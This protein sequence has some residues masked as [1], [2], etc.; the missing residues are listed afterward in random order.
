MDNNKS[1][2]RGIGKEIKQIHKEIK[3][4]DKTNSQCEV[5]K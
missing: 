4:E 1:S 5:R 2:Q 3:P